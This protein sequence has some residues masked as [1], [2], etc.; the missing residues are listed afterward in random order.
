MVLIPRDGE[1][2][3]RGVVHD[4][5]HLDVVH[6]A[7]D[8]TRS[9]AGNIMVRSQRQF[10][11]SI[12]ADLALVIHGLELLRILI[13]RI[14][15]PARAHRLT[16]DIRCRIGKAAGQPLSELNVQGMIRRII[17]VLG[18]AYGRILRIRHQVVVRKAGMTKDVSGVG[19]GILRY[20]STDQ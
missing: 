1:R 4:A 12:A 19:V 5:A 11:G 14:N 20:D 2:S 7:L 3:T 17:G 8:P 10:V 18:D 9:I 13:E 16:P 15:S 6:N